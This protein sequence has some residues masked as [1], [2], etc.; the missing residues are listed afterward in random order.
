ML[1]LGDCFKVVPSVLDAVNEALSSVTDPLQVQMYQQKIQSLRQLIKEAA[2]PAEGVAALRDL[3]CGIP[4]IVNT[5][6]SIMSGDSGA[7]NILR[8]VKTLIHVFEQVSDILTLFTP[9]DQ[10]GN[11]NLITQIAGPGLKQTQMLADALSN[12]PILKR[13]GKKNKLGEVRLCVLYC[14]S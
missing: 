6:K 9:T 14:E 12:L 13:A 1:L 7:E 5:V 11:G 8:G 4:E 2:F 3:I 10:P